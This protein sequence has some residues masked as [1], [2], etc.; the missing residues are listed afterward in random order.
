MQQTSKEVA[1]VLR[2]L[3]EALEDGTA[4]TLLLADENIFVP[5]DA[6]VRVEYE[7]GGGARELLV[8]VTWG[9][10][11][12]PQLI[13]RH[14]E[15]VHDSLGRVYDVIIYGAPRLDGTWEGWIE[16][17]PLSASQPTRSTGR[18]T[19]QPDRAA[20]EYWA[21]GLESVYLAGALERAS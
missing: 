9:E 13:H 11:S 18:E 4:A 19:T 12:A 16:F 6:A 5:S 3:A 10:V 7:R 20:L 1:S 8:R 15:R 17:A 2:L 14:S 21:T